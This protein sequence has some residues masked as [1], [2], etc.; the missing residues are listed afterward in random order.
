MIKIVNSKVRC[1]KC[2][3]NTLKLIEV[4]KD[5]EIIWEQ[6]NGQFDRDN[7]VLEP[8]DPYK[9]QAQCKCGHAWTIRKALQIDE[10]IK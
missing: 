5:H 7:G 10:V 3:S 6:E 4:W 8:G 2:K 9:V 1:P